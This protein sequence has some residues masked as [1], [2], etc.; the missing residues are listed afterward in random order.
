L[1]ATLLTTAFIFALVGVGGA[2]CMGRD[3]FQA[4]RHSLAAK[5]LYYIGS[6]LVALA[7]CVY[8]AKVRTRQ[9]FLSGFALRPSAPRF[10]ILAAMLGIWLAFFVQVITPGGVARIRFQTYFSLGSIVLL[11][12]PFLEE[13]VMRGF[14]YPAFRSATP[15]VVSILF[16]CAIDVL[17][18]HFRK[19]WIPMALFG[20]GLVNMASCLL[21]EHT[22]SLWPSM[23]LHFAYN[24]PF[25]VLASMR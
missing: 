8:F 16:V 9:D 19:F 5:P 6:R 2:L 11:I 25:A 12:G 22:K 13:A 14:F 18:F 3:A 4:F 21:R 23:T 1:I 7:V 15:L 20:V 24:I 17:L 10:L